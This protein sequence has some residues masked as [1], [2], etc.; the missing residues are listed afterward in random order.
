MEDRQ[1]CAAVILS[2]GKNSRMG[3]QNKAFLSLGKT[4]F[5][6]QIMGTV[7]KNFDEIIISTRQPEL[8]ENYRAKT[9]VDIFKVNSPLAGIHAALSFMKSE[10]A[11][12][13]TC[14]TPLIKRAVI[15]ILVN[16]I[17]P[18]TDVVVPYSGTYFQPLCAVYSKKCTPFIEEMLEK[19]QVKVD[20]LFARVQVKKIEYEKFET[21]D[22]HLDSF[23]NIN[24]P[25][26]LAHLQKKSLSNI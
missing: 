24:T 17:T 14:D 3:G 15:D 4:R 12:I 23:F 26:D 8:Y 1:N 22:P 6:D 13:T 20:R 10:Y 19:K 18:E 5:L 11:F 7:Y 16:A 2:G 9:A 21:V 25:Q